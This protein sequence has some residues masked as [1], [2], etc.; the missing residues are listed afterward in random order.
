MEQ[1]QVGLR[2]G[3]MMSQIVTIGRIHIMKQSNI[4]NKL[5]IYIIFLL[6]LTACNTNKFEESNIISI[7]EKKDT[8]CYYSISFEDTSSIVDLPWAN[9]LSFDI[10]RI[11]DMPEENATLQTIIN[12][13]IKIAMTSWI[14]GKVLNTDAVNLSI[15]CHSSRYLS[16][17]NSFMYESRDIDVINDYI[18]IDM[19]TGQR[20]YLNDL[21][22]V[23]EEFVNYLRENASKIK[24][25]PHPF[26]QGVPN[27][28]EYS[29][30]ELLEELNRCS[31][32]Q[33]Q[34][35]QNGYFSID[36]SIGSLLFRNSFF[37]REGM[38]V[39]TLEQGGESLI[40]LDVDDIEPFLKVDKW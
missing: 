2:M 39:I 38:L 13:N 30:S 28:N 18:T 11:H 12:T 14:N 4:F 7:K 6:L 36:D 40:T 26:W 20:V 37:L 21:I 25:P 27:L 31:Y 19:L 3:G 16:F 9:D 33:E 32:T 8:D 5:I 23:N 29:P 24:A 1:M 22:E 34:L 10:I 15:T 35:I 17:V